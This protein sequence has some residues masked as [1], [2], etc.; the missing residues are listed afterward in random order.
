[1]QEVLVMVDS[2]GVVFEGAVLKVV[3][4]AGVML[5]V[6]VLIWVKLTVKCTT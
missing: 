1:M 6:A 2:A 4:L 3:V 5:V